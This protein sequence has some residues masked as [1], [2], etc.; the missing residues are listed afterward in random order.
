MLA[1]FFAF[2]NNINDDY[3]V[4]IG[5]SDKAGLWITIVYLIVGVLTPIFGWFIGKITLNFNYL[6]RYLLNNT[7]RTSYT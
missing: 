1:A 3:H 7:S 2:T 5:I 4:R 6:A